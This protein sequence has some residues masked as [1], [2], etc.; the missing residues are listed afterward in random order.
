MRSCGYKSFLAAVGLSVFLVFSAGDLG[1]AEK[2]TQDIFIN[3][4]ARMACQIPLEDRYVVVFDPAVD[5]AE[6]QNCIEEQLEKK[7]VQVLLDF[8]F[9]LVE[10]MK[11]D[12]PLDSY[13]IRAIGR[14]TG[15]RAVLMGQIN[16]AP[17]KIRVTYRMIR[18]ETMEIIGVA[19]CRLPKEDFGDCFVLFDLAPPTPGDGN[20]L[21]APRRVNTP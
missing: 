5:T 20:Y 15:A 16:V 2:P 1:S 18:I 17:G 4:V 14:R 11:G 8:Q 21:P 10:K 9:S 13:E 19:S 7:I 3:E 12:Y 6:L